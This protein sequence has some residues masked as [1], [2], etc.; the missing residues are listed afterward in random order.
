M[1]LGV[2]KDRWFLGISLTEDRF[3]PGADRDALVVDLF[4]FAVGHE[5]CDDSTVDVS[6][7]YSGV[8]LHFFEHNHVGFPG[9]L[10]EMFPESQI[11]NARSLKPGRLQ[12]PNATGGFAIIPGVS[13]LGPG[14]D[15]YN[16]HWVLHGRRIIT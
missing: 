10:G 11:A 8:G 9:G 15:R 12:V 4:F 16:V 7:N 3:F 6:S 13:A 14:V 5:G 2:F 1:L